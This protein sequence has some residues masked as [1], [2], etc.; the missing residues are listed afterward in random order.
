[1]NGPAHIFYEARE[2]GAAIELHFVSMDNQGEVESS[3]GLHFS[4]LVPFHHFEL[5]END[6]LFIPGCESWL[7][8]DP[9]FLKQCGDFFHWLNKQYANGANICSVC[10]GAFLL[11]ESGILD[12]KSCTTHWKFYQ[13][14]C[15]KYPRVRIEKN[16]LFVIDDQVYSS[17]GVSSGL[18]LA[19]YILEEQF[20]IKLAT[21]VAKEVVIYFR[22]SPSDPQLSVFLQYRNHL[23]TRIHDV[24]D[25]MIRHISQPFTTDVLA[26]NV[27]MSPRNLTR[28]FKKTTGIT[29]G[30][31]Q[32]KLRVEK[33]VN[34]LA[35]GHKVDFVTRECGLNSPNQLRTILKKH[36][37]ILPTSI[38]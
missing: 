23:D 26:E 15:D 30:A 1:M 7:F 32:E 34:L 21:D 29:I 37:E 36:E 18:D 17:A 25:Y 10:T 3:A 14:F 12:G 2:Y 22:R 35:N 33:A 4:R 13:R 6:F 9:D 28:L 5:S 16:R 8:S 11:A 38:V 19:L 31:Y 24:Q 20:G 27:H